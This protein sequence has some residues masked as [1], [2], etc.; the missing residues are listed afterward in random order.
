V[1]R[2]PER[3]NEESKAMTKPKGAY[4][5]VF[6]QKRTMA[7]CLGDPVGGDVYY[8]KAKGDRCACHVG[9][10]VVGGPGD[11]KVYTAAWTPVGVA[12][13]RAAAALMIDGYHLKHNRE[14]YSTWAGKPLWCG[15]KV[16]RPAKR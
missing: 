10:A 3:R 4:S 11:V 16:A 2:N 14:R 13:T 7:T 8:L 15:G 5:I 6:S 1:R 12:E 9:Y